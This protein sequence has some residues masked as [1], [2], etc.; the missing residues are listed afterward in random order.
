MSQRFVAP[1]EVG[2]FSNI[3]SVTPVPVQYV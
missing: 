2:S 3:S 1:V